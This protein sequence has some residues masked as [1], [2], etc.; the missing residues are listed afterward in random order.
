MRPAVSLIIPCLN[1][2]ENILPT[3]ERIAALD[4]A[5]NNWEVLI[6]D[7]GSTDDTAS[8]TR[9]AAAR[10]G[11]LHLI[12]HPHNMGLGAAMKTGF[13]NA[14]GEIVCSMDSDCTFAP[15]RL[16]ELIELVRK[17]ADIATGSPWHPASTKGDVHP[18]RKMLSQSCSHLYRVLLRSELHCY[19]SIFRAYRR[20]VIERIPVTSNGFVAVAEFLVAA[21]RAGYKVA[22][23]PVKLDRRVHGESKINISASIRAHVRLMSRLAWLA[24]TPHSHTAVFSGARAR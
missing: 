7:D 21:L 22:E 12:Q 6:V 20:E 24:W 4:P 15:E 14:K 13:G 16:P 11:W 1:E 3:I 23:M 18:V 5:A 9:A 2:Q 19:T 10:Y 8:V 17:G